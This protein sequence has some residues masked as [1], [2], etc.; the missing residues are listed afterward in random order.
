RRR[1]RAARRRVGRH[2]GAR[3]RLHAGGPRTPD[4]PGREAVNVPT[5]TRPLALAFALCL[6]A[7]ADAAVVITFEDL[8]VPSAGWFNGNPGGLQQGDVVT[9]PWSS[10]GVL[11][12]NTF[13]VDAD[14]GY[15]YWS[16]FAFSNVSDSTTAGYGNQYAAAPGSG[17]QSS[18]YAVAYSAATVTLPVVSNVAGFRIAN[19][20]YALLSMRDGDQFSQPLPVGGWFRVAATGRRGGSVTGTTAFF[21]ADRRGTS[22]PGL[23]AGWDWFDLSTLGEVDQVAFAFSGS[24][25]GAHGLNTP[26]YFAL[27]DFTFTTGVPEPSGWSLLAGLAAVVAATWRRWRPRANW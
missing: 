24:D 22:P 13:G 9:S 15:S 5:A 20:T 8:T 3:R 19:T 25:V 14:W 4:H 17:W 21:L 26:A 6:A 1:R 12:S 18:T 10:G 23:V 7:V 11:F 16:G 2:A 27:D